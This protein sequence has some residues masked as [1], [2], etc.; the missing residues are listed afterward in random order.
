MGRF[1]EFI[2]GCDIVVGLS[3]TGNEQAAGCGKP[4]VAFPTDGG[5]YNRRFIASQKKLLGKCLEIVRPNPQDAVDK[6]FEI[7]GD[8]SLYRDMSRAGVRRIGAPGGS[9]RLAEE[10]SKLLV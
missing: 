8:E 6:I 9:A 3:G 4:I 7:S 2:H 5:Q 1:A 10:I